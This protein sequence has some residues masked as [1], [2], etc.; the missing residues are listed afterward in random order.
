M[1]T[2]SNNRPEL[3]TFAILAFNQESFIEEAIKGALSQTYSPLEIILSDDHSSDRTFDIMSSMAEAYQGEHRIMLR[4]SASNLGIGR[5]VNEVVS[6]AKGEL[7]VVAAGDD[8]SLP[9]RTEIVHREWVASGKKAASVFSGFQEIDGSGNIISEPLLPKQSDQTN[10]LKRVAVWNEARG[11]AHAFTK[12][13]F[14]LFGLLNADVVSEDAAINFR[15]WAIGPVLE[16]EA[17]LVLYRV[18]SQ[19]ISSYGSSDA[20]G[21]PLSKYTQLQRARV[22]CFKQYL[23]DLDVLELEGMAPRETIVEARSLT[24]DLLREAQVRYSFGCTRRRWPRLK[25]AK[26]YALPSGAVGRSMRMLLR[27]VYPRLDS[28]ELRRGRTN[29]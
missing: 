18:H 1:G 28:I 6:C 23:R 15:S 4:R 9:Q 12:A 29:G 2:T 7:I 13:T 22:A 26:R 27:A 20:I 3:V 21:S 11:C 19:A 16:I 8:V 10:L 25:L 14:E 5:H 24:I 17:S